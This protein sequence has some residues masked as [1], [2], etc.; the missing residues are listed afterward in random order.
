MVEGAENL[1]TEG[2]MLK[3]H[4]KILKNKKIFYLNFKKIDIIICTALIPA[5]KL[6][7]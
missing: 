1:E 2:G 7:R 4:L 5:K 6:Q 3:K